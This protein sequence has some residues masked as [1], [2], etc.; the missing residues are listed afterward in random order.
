MKTSNPFSTISYNTVDF[1]RT[2]LDEQV[3]R[4]RLLFY[5]FVYHYPEAD[6]RKPHIHLVMFPNGQVQTDSYIDLLQELDPN[7]VLKP[8]GVMPFQKSK[9]ADWYLYSSHDVAYLAS[10]GQTRQYHYPEE[11][12]VTSDKDYLHELIA[13]IDRTRYTKTQEFVQ[14]AK[15][16]VSFDDMIE[17]GQ[18][19]VTAFM[20][21]Q[22]MF[23]RIVLN[24]TDRGGRATHT[25]KCDPDTGEVIEPVATEMTEP[26]RAPESPRAN[27][28][29]Y[30]KPD[31]PRKQAEP[32][33]AQESPGEPK[34]W[35][36]RYEEYEPEGEELPY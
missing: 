11:R 17:A 4:R 29:L 10:K 34:A 1:L 21:Y 28:P 26:Q 20:Q 36:E 14:R 30:N 27:E 24:Q 33:R 7:N 31:T 18:I 13:T 2:T 35:Y 16:G 9:W 3:A 25:P 23:D 22:K 32:Q 15:S 6:E 19:P 8:L 12:F 5:A